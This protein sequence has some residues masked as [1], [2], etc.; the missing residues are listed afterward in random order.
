MIGGVRV[1][2]GLILGILTSMEIVSRLPGSH[3]CQEVDMTFRL[4]VSLLLLLFIVGACE[5][6]EAQRA[7]SGVMKPPE[8]VLSLDSTN[9]GQHLYLTVGQHIKIKLDELN[10]PVPSDDNAPQVS[11]TVVT[12]SGE[13]V[14]MHATERVGSITYDFEATAPGEARLTIPYYVVAA[15]TQQKFMLIVSVKPDAQ[16]TMLLDARSD[17]Q[18][19]TATVGQPI[20]IKLQEIGPEEYGEPKISSRAIRFRD[21]VFGP[22]IPAG[23]T[24]IYTFE[25]VAEGE[26]RI[27]ILCKRRP[28]MQPRSPF[29]V[30]IRVKPAAGN[31]HPPSP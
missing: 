14:D 29:A 16:N 28:P 26:A 27:T 5:H 1:D 25:A 7:V 10:E 31:A 15:K 19:I 4:P 18:R 3:L 23:G 30:T 12:P 11:S 24:P 17:G 6:A 8:Y 21:V 22:P 20:K 9:N 13:M 2:H